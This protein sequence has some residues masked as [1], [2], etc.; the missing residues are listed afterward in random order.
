VAAAPGPVLFVEIEDDRLV[1]AGRGRGLRDRLDLWAIAESFEADYM[2]HCLAPDAVPAAQSWEI[3]IVDGTVRGRDGAPAPAL[4]VAAE[5]GRNT[6]GT[7][8]ARLRIELV[9]RPSIC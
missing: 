7:S 6:S 9:A 1:G 5:H 2:D 3:G 8:W 4:R